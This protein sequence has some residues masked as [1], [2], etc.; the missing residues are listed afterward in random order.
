MSNLSP[1]HRIVLYHTSS[2]GECE[3]AIPIIKKIKNRYENIF[4]VVSF[5]SPSGFNFKTDNQLI[6]LK[7]YLPFD[8]KSAARHFFKALKPDLWLISAYDVWP[9]HIMVASELKI[10]ILMTSATLAEDS[11]R[12]KGISKIFNRF[13]YD[14]FNYIFPRSNG[15]YERFLQIYPFGDRMEVCG[16]NR[17][18]RVFEKYENLMNQEEMKIFHD[19]GTKSIVFIA[20]SIWPEDEKNILNGLCELLEKHDNLKVIL[21]PHEIDENHL[22]SIEFHF[23]PGNMTIARYSEFYEK[24]GTDSRVAIID[25]IGILARIYKSTQIAYIGGSFSSGVHNVM[26]PA[27]FRQPVIF[28]PKHVNS[29]EALDLLKEGCGFCVRNNEEFIQ[30]LNKLII[31]EKYREQLGQKSYDYVKRKTGA[32]A[33]CF[34]IIDEKFLNKL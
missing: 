8:I 5:F 29:Q 2:V 6:D 20:G 13:I 28:G 17:F 9:N 18:D 14:K 22:R 26:E 3:Q 4:V 7:I 34:R 21:V 23:Q 10:P 19:S 31:E 15:D 33:K 25:K 11:R 1:E 12:Y 16:D 24:G 32:T 30:I 27:V